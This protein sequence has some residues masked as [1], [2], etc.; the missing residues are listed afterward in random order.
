MA[1]SYFEFKA[2]KQCELAD[3]FIPGA[4]ACCIDGSTEVCNKPLDEA[5]VPGLYRS[6][7]LNADPLGSTTKPVSEAMVRNAVAIGVALVMLDV[8][9]GFHFV[10]VDDITVDKFRV[11]D[12]K[13]IDPKPLDWATLSSAYGNGSIEQAWSVNK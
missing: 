9:T 4:I 11:A 12:P 10:L 2:P 1:A 13:Y 6:L 7:K 3:Q 8:G 5:V